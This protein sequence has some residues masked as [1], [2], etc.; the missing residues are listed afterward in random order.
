MAISD[1]D[2]QLGEAVS[3]FGIADCGRLAFVA[4]AAQL[5]WAANVK[6]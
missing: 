2:W 1:V 3:L 4:V 5:K 6:V